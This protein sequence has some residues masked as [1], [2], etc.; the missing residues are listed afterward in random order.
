MRSWICSASSKRSEAAAR[1]WQVL[2][3]FS[4]SAGATQWPQSSEAAGRAA[5]RFMVSVRVD[6]PASEHPRV[7][8]L[9][10]EHLAL[11]P[12]QSRRPADL[13]AVRVGAA[14]MAPPNDKR[15]NKDGMNRICPA[16]TVSARRGHGPRLSTPRVRT[17]EATSRPHSRRT[18]F[19]S[20]GRAFQRAAG[21]SN[22][23][24]VVV[25]CANSVPSGPNSR[26]SAVANWRPQ[27]ITL[28][29][30]RTRPTLGDRP[31]T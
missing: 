5:T 27:W 6:I 13:R 9:A 4:H 29:S 30:A 10:G 18:F 1:D 24:H 14:S 26:A 25:A 17:S 19:S 7:S 8:A 20:A 2:A 16:P 31:R 15:S 23:R 11:V 3:D 22:T 28:P 21:M 12:L